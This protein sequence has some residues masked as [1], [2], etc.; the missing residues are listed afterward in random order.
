MDRFFLCLNGDETFLSV[1]QALV[2]IVYGLMISDCFC[3]SHGESLKALSLQGGGGGDE[4][5]W[6]TTL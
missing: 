1:S 3:M 5:L 6:K 4:V 2:F